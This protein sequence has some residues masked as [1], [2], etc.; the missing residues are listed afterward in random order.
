MAC[1]L[2]LM[3]SAPAC[4]AWAQVEDGPN[5]DGN[6]R[7]A[8]LSSSRDLDD[9]ANLAALAGEIS[10]KQSI[11][12]DQRFE[13]KVR[14]LSEDMFGTR[15]NRVDWM[16]AMWFLR[17][18]PVDLRIGRQK[19]RW[20]KAD[21]I[22]PTDFF[23][24]NDYTV[25]LPLEDDRYQSIP[26]VRA[27]IHLN[28]ADSLS[29]VAAHGFTPTRVPWPKPSPV[30]VKNDEPSDWQLGVRWQHTGERMDWSLSAFHGN[31]TL[32]LLSAE[33]SASAP[34]LLR[35]YARIDALGADV[36]R[37]FGEFGFRAEAAY[38]RRSVGDDRQSVASGYML[39]A[40]IDR[41]L[42]RWNFNVQGVLHHTPDW[43]DPS[44]DPDP[45]RQFAAG[46]NAIIHGQQKRTMFGVTTRVASNWR[47]DTLQ[48]ELLMVAN[49]SPRSIYLRPLVTYA[50]SDRTKLRAG[51]EY[52]GGDDET[53]FGALKR[54]RVGLVDWQ[55]SF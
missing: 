32:P 9:R 2:A 26:A 36:A 19:I 47:H 21:G 24:P 41:S 51:Y 35:H 28:E 4:D 20:G 52:Y 29:L 3:A 8:W 18:G 16:Q 25:L 43:Q 53:Y 46:Q 12:E 44:D 30:A 10:L 34:A 13:F 54:N 6:V 22:N 33:P 11:G 17:A 7:L 45:L 49:A 55:L 1:V 50:L 27:D 15:E 23:T 40:G 37:N 39:V 5:I 42:G 38:I 14:V 48:V 31:A